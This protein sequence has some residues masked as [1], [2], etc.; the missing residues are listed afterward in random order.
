[1]PPAKTRLRNESCASYKTAHPQGAWHRIIPPSTACSMNIHALRA[2]LMASQFWTL[3][4][5]CA[6]VVV[7][8]IVEARRVEIRR[9]TL[10]A[11]C[12][13][14]IAASV[15]TAR[16]PPRTNRIYYDEQIYQGVARN[17][18]E[19]H[20]AQ[21]CNDGIVEYGRLQCR[22]EEYNKE[23]YGYPYLLSIAYR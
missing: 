4:A 21:M 17:M 9:S 3:E 6:C 15:L 20:R 1:K 11:G 7:A 10:A 16:V 8:T 23:P 2:F 18:A 12:I 5:Q 14:A 19:L 22:L 13:V